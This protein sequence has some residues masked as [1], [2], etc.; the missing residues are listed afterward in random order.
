MNQKVTDGRLPPN[1][2]V[3]VVNYKQDRYL[4]HLLRSIE[5]QTHPLCKT[6]IINNSPPRFCPPGGVAVINND[7]NLGYPAA[8]NQGIRWG[9]EKGYDAFLLLNADVKL[10]D[11]CIEMLVKTPGDIIQPLILLINRPGRV[12]CAGLQ[13]TPLGI[14]YCMKYLQKRE[15]MDDQV[16]PIPS[17]SGAAMFIHKRVVDTIGMLDEGFFLYLEDVDYCI[18]ARKEGFSIMLQPKAVAWHNYRIRVSLG[19]I[20]KLIHNSRAIRKNYKLL[21]ECL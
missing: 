6:V 5:K 16:K 13:L 2:A 11:R 20:K 18:R 7:I 8:V 21:K 9:M 3:I 1:V 10:E 15:S 19:K 17:A 14:A 4:Y 12:N